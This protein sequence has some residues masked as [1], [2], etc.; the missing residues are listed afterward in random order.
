M[1]LFLD[2]NVVLDVL[3]VR[4]PWYEDGAAVLSLIDSNHVTGFV[5]DHT[6]STIFYLLRR[7]HG[8][9]KASAAL[10]DLTKLLTVAAV[11][12]TAVQQALALGWGD[13]EDALQG[14]CAMNVGADFFVTR[15]PKH[16]TNLPIPVVTPGEALA[17]AAA[18]GLTPP[19]D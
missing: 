18:Q 1:K 13:F 2:A 3:T 9:P 16:F 6:V 12:H 11:D 7:A 4:Q 17:H 10:V 19:Q 15:D 5:A 14:I 8:G